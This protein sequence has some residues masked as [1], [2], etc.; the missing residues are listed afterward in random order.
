[1]TVYSTHETSVHDGQ[2]VE[3]YEFAGSYKTYRYT[4]NDVA[5]TVGGSVYVPIPITRTN[6]K[7]GVHD[8]DSIEVRLELPITVELVRD[9]GFQVTP[10]SLRLA[11]FRVH[12]GTDFSVDIATY[13]RGNV[14]S[15]TCSDNRATIVVPSVFGSAM[16]GNVPSVYYQSPCNHVL[17]DSGCKISRAAN[18]V[19]TTVVVIEGNSVQVASAGGF[20]DGD[21]VGGEVADTVHNER[22]MIIEHSGTLLTVNYPFSN[23]AP[24]T[25]VEVTR[26]CDH[27]FDSDCKVRFNNQINH[28]GFPF[29]PSINPFESGF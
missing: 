4:S 22:R 28:G 2:P 11:I 9:Y 26:G 16:L 20:A 5:V 17:F 3:C 13:W 29:I 23:L 15:I 18:T 24:G 12:R 27:G 19:A 7:A 21:F 6:V 14:S 8:E 1:M 25:G 10:P